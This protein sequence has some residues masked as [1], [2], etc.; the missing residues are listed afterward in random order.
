MVSTKKCHGRRSFEGHEA[1]KL[2]EICDEVIWKGAII[3]N[4]EPHGYLGLQSSLP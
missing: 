3:K 4:A 1:E 2:I